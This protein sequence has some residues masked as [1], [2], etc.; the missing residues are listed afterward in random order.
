MTDEQLHSMTVDQLRARFNS[1]PAYLQSLLAR[2]RILEQGV[3]WEFNLQERAQV[4]S[5]TASGHDKQSPESGEGFI[6]RTPDNS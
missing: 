3:L 6:Y 4:A 1:A 5:H 2:K